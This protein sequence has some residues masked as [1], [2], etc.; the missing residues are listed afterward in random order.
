VAW[1]WRSR[2]VP[3]DYDGG[4]DLFLYDNGRLGHFYTLA[5]CRLIDTRQPQEGP[6]L[7][8]GAV[9]TWHLHGACDI[10]ETAKA[11]AVN[12]T[13][14]QATWPGYLTFYRGDMATAPVASTINFGAGQTRANNAVLRLAASAEGTLKVLPVVANGGTVHVILDVAGYFE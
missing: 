13:V 4:Y 12:V 11:V 8:S 2:R 7:V 1:P 6:A 5:P 9:E 10:P 14:T 3:G